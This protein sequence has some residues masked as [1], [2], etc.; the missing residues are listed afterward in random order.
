M[1]EAIRHLRHYLQDAAGPRSAVYARAGNTALLLID[2]Q[3]FTTT[4]NQGMGRL[5]SERG[6]DRE[7][8]EYYLQ[9]E[10]R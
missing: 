5:A 9:A 10:P 4:R 6:I 8:D 1:N 7:F 3:H 2:A